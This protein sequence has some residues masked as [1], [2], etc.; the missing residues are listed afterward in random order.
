MICEICDRDV[1]ELEKHHLEPGNKKSKTIQ[2]C[3]CCGDQLHALFTN[4]ELKKYYNTLEKIKQ[5]SKVQ[6]YILWV[7]K[8][9]PQRIRYHGKIK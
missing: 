2:V 8:K 7:R 3:Y 1:E 4:K 5:S 9:N 6:K